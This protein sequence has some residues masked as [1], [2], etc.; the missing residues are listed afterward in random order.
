MREQA[1]HD[2]SDEYSYDEETLEEIRHGNERPES[3]WE[4]CPA[5]VR[6][7]LDRSW[8]YRSINEEDEENRIEIEKVHLDRRIEKRED[9]WCDS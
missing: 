6:G 7:P 8:A 3:E 9:E 4:W 2:S 1:M 5:V